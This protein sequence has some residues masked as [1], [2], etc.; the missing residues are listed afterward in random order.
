MTDNHTWLGFTLDAQHYAVPLAAVREV[1][2]AG[3][4]TPVP[5]SPSEVLGVVNLRGQIVCVLDGR[6]RFGLPA[7]HERHDDERIM[8]IE[9]GDETIGMRIDAVGEM[10]LAEPA[11]IAAPPPS[12]ANR[13]GDPVNGVLTVADGFVA[14]VD[15]ERLCRLN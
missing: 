15:V 8:V 12:R 7:L 9:Q 10:I 14:M 6:H 3:D 4:I 5:G 13:K 2:R 1:I 11:D